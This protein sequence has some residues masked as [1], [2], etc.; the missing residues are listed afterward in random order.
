MHRLV[1]ILVVSAVACGHTGSSSDPPATQIAKAYA[2]PGLPFVGHWTRDVGNGELHLLHFYPSGI[3]AFQHA[4]AKFPISRSYGRWSLEDGV[5]VIG[6][7]HS[8]P[9]DN[10]FPLATRMVFAA[11]AGTL[12]LTAGADR[13]TWIAH[14]TYGTSREG[15]QQRAA[16]GEASWTGMVERAERGAP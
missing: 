8:E 11:D 6:V 10:R 3:V 15:W 7:M 1:W 13:S 9:D 14:D 5:I 16:H 4:T 12:T 2:P